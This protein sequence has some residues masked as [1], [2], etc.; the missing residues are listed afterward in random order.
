MAVRPSPS[1]AMSTASPCRHVHWATEPP[2]R[3]HGEHLA[4]QPFVAGH[5]RRVLRVPSTELHWAPSA[6]GQTISFTF[7]AQFT[8]RSEPRSSS[9]ERPSG[10]QG[11]LCSSYLGPLLRVPRRSGPA[12]PEPRAPPRLAATSSGSP[13]RKYA[14]TG[15]SELHSRSSPVSVGVFSARPIPSS[16]GLCRQQAKLFLS[17]WLR[18]PLARTTILAP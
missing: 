12:R 4:P 8:A 18:R 1:G 17:L 14:A 11:L 15:S 6:A 3:G 5:C 10:P 13:S 7:T 16:A 2:R 9:G